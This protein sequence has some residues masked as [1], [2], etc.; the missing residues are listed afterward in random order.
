MDPRKFGA[1]TFATLAFHLLFLLLTEYF[2]WSIEIGAYKFYFLLLISFGFN[3]LF[4]ATMPLL[5]NIGSAYFC[6]DENAAEYQSIHLT[7]VGFRAVFGPLFGIWLLEYFDYSG[8]FA[9][10]ILLLLWSIYVMISSIKTK[11]IS[12]E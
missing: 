4:A 12:K 7:M 1:F 11:S 3:G 10:G 2:P 9:I 8:V 5:W 6:K